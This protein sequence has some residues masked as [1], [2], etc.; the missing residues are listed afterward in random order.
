MQKYHR[1]GE[2]GGGRGHRYA[3]VEKGKGGFCESK[4]RLI[5]VKDLDA[6][7]VHRMLCLRE[8]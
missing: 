5:T 3:S 7:V 4:S 2:E 8:E 6:K 1:G